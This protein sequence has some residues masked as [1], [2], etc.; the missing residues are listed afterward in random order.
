MGL[1][2]AREGPLTAG[3]QLKAPHLEDLLR[4]RP[5]QALRDAQSVSS[6][7]FSY[8][9]AGRAVGA[10]PTLISLPQFFLSCAFSYRL[11]PLNYHVRYRGTFAI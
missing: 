8:S 2:V 7:A 11:S 10:S 3:V 4:K 5:Q 9:P 1:Q 6:F